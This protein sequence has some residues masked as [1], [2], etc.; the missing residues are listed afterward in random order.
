MRYTHISPFL[1]SFHLHLKGFS[2]HDFPSQIHPK[3]LPYKSLI[4]F[5]DLEEAANE[6]PRD[7]VL[8][9]K[10]SARTPDDED[11]EELNEA[12]QGAQEQAQDSSASSKDLKMPSSES[13]EED[14]DNQ[15]SSPESPS[16][17]K[18]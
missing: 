7:E 16:F 10:Q 14:E 5:L 3:I 1:T 11:D 9:V 18:L 15:P 17:G 6:N 13:A 8:A 4:P 2:K 12:L